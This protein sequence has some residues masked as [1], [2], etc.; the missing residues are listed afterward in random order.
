MEL[1]R[2]EPGLAVH[3]IERMI[4]FAKMKKPSMAAHFEEALENP[5]QVGAK[6]AGG[7]IVAGGT[8]SESGAAARVPTRKATS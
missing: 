1:L 8:M 2:E 5:K 6:A 3:R 4:S 7:S